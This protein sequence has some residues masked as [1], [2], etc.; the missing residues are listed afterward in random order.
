LDSCDTRAKS[1]T[2]LILPKIWINHSRQFIRMGHQSVAGWRVQKGKELNDFLRNLWIQH[3]HLSS[4]RPCW[5]F[6]QISGSAS[7]I[8]RKRHFSYDSNDDESNETITWNEVA[9]T[10]AQV[11]RSGGTSQRSP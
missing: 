8:Q 1:K 5:E 2:S 4:R 7:R 9:P 11:R 6:S 10:C 3:L